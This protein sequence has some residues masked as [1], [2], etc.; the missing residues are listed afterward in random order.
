MK[1]FL[2]LTIF[3]AAMTV[4]FSSCLKDKGFDNGE[5]GVPVIEKKGVSFPA[6]TIGY[7]LS[8]SLL[9]S[10]T[11]LPLG[12]PVVAL[13]AIGAQ[14]QDVRITLTTDDD[15]VTN[16]GLTPLT[17]SEYTFPTSFVIKAGKLI[18]TLP[19]I[20]NNTSLLD[21]STS[22]GIGMK[23]LTADNGFQVASNMSELVIQLNIRNIYDGIVE[24]K[25]KTFHPTNASLGGRVSPYETLLIT[26]GATSVSLGEPHR[27]A[28]GSGSVLSG[29]IN[30]QYTVDPATNDVTVTNVG[31]DPVG[32]PV[33]NTVGYNSHYDPATKTIFAEW[34]YNGRIFTD[35]IT[36]I[37]IR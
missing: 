13:E 7:P 2:K 26:S 12:A 18:D 29:A 35:T 1:N 6:S 17:S 23:I 3:G 32:T 28:D 19:I 8:I 16:A 11:P 14:A 25:G 20:L 5:Y 9:P 37:S 33:S 22:Y 10:T 21:P 36:W 24:L 27:W 30:P 15:L 34:T 31:T 4:A